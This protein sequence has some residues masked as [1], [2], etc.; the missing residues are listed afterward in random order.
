MVQ[1]LV[2]ENSLQVA[3]GLPGIGHGQLSL[4]TVVSKSDPGLSRY[5]RRL[6]CVHEAAHA[7][8]YALGG[9]KIAQVAV[10]PEGATNWTVKLRKGNVLHDLWGVCEKFED[11][12]AAR[13]RTLKSRFDRQMFRA[14]LKPFPSQYRR[15]IWRQIRVHLSG[16]LISGTSSR[17]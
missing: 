16:T 6:T 12:P 15:K 2:S 13:C 3:V 5:E 1:W 10:A 8:M 11:N 9:Y 4:V 7:V 14:S 17:I